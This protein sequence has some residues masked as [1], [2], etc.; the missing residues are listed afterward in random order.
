MAKTSSVARQDKRERMVRKYAAQRAALKKAAIDMALSPE[1]RMDAR[2]QLANLPRNSSSV[3]L[4]NRCVVTG[5]S[6]AVY[7]EFM[8]C[9]ITFREMA[10]MGQLPGVHKASW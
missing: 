4:H 2:E 1:E 3:R 6:H 7:R 10:H 5:R 9:R 8:L